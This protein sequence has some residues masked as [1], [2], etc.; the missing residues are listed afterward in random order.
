[1]SKETLICPD[2]ENEMQKNVYE[3]AG[4]DEADFI[5]IESQTKLNI[6]LK[7]GKFSFGQD[8]VIHALVK[9]TYHCPLCKK[10]L[11]DYRIER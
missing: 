8:K 6:N 9:D 10:I 11:V 1:M 4:L 5:P 2:C 3:I 7:F